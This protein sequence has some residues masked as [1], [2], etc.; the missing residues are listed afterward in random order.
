[1]SRH[2]DTAT[3][4]AALAQRTGTRAQDWFLVL[5]ARY[6]MEVVFRALREVHGAGHV[7][8]QI[9]TC[10]T[11]VTPIL[12]AGL[13]PVHGDVSAA[14]VSLDPDRLEVG[15]TTRAVV[16]QHTFGIVDH[17]SARRVADLARGVGAL[18]VEDCAHGLG[19]MATDAA[20]D[21]LAD[22]SVH[23]FGVE[24]M[25]PTRFGGAIWVNPAGADPEVRDRVVAALR[26]LPVAGPRLD[27]VTRAYRGQVAVLNR[28]PAA[29]AGP[30]RRGLTA[31]RLFEP[32]VAPAEGRAT[33]PYRP[34]RPSA[35]VVEQVA[36]A[37]PRLPE[38]ERARGA[39]V[40]AYLASLDGVVEVPAGVRPGD[41]LVR[42]PFLAADGAA[43]ER[44][45]AALR[46]AGVYAGSWYRPALFPGVEDP[47]AYGYTPG[48][49]RLVTSEDVVARVVNLP[50][51]GD[52]EQA[53]RA[54]EVVRSATA[55]GGSS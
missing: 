23:S 5:K 46:A 36:A 54:A 7:V 40:T 51:T 48:D 8:T 47:R 18:V 9:V 20:G 22:V 41:P 16:V 12:V 39:V 2:D 10:S 43:A 31:L 28:L 29:V 1:M 24:K 4:T 6:G 30:L 45:I 3:V 14:T 35:W 53:R 21:P 37:L 11:A 50:T 15:A 19:R 17:E 55:A 26:D 34:M 33:L 13:T 44:T 32:A 49:P 42:L 27:L 38:I 52:P 25:L